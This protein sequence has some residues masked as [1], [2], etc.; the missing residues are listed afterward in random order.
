[1]EAKDTL[2]IFLVEDHPDSRN[3]LFFYLK[4]QGHQVRS[5]HTVAEALETI[6]AVKP[7]VLISDIGLP[8]GTG[9]ELLTRLETPVFAIA[10]TGFGRPADVRRSRE[11]GFREHLTKPFPLQ[12]LDILLDNALSEKNAA[13]SGAEAA[14]PDLT[15]GT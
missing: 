12:K 6:P 13:G 11:A 10:M 9:W 14:P 1:M 7:D 5:A 2:S 3:Y 8:D 4:D 15:G